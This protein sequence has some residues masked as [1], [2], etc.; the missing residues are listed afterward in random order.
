MEAFS[1]GRGDAPDVRQALAPVMPDVGED[2]S[3]VGDV[4]ANVY[5]QC[6]ELMAG[7]AAEAMLLSDRVPEP[8]IDDLR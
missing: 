4:F 6:I 3:S 8:P 1:E 2:R 5:S 7:R